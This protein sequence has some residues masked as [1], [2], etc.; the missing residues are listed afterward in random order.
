[1]PNGLA[2]ALGYISISNNISNQNPLFV[3]EA[4]RNLK[5]QPNSPAYLNI[6][7]FQ[8]TKFELIGLQ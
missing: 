5:L 7:G 8:D 3:D 2:G 4:N 1:M 6:P